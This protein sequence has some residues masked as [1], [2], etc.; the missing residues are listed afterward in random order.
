MDAIQM[1]RT[2]RQTNTG[3]RRVV[4]ASMRVGRFEVT[5]TI[6]AQCGSLRKLVCIYA[7]LFFVLLASCANPY[8][9][10]I[11]KIDYKAEQKKGVIQFTDPKLYKREALIN[12][13]RGD[14][15]YLKELLKKSEGIGRSTGKSHQNLPAKQTPNLHCPMLDCRLSQ[16]HLAV[17]ADSASIVSQDPKHRGGL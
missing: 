6:R 15:K 13:R 14:L 1:I 12:E 5:H 4:I 11:N 2:L 3:L 17:A 8:G 10:S 7:P 16:G 9:V